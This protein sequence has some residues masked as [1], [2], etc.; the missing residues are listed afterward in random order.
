MKFMK[1]IRMSK[2][3]RMLPKLQAKLEISN[4]SITITKFIIFIFLTAHWLGCFYFILA[5][6]NGFNQDSW[7]NNQLGYK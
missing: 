7:V 2:L 1:M 4:A 5:R 6:F 3:A